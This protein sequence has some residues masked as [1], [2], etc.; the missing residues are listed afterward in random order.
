MTVSFRF[1]MAG[2]VDSE[3]HFEARAN[4]YGV[5]ANFLQALRREGI[6]TVGHLAF[7]VF[8]PGAEFNEREFDNWAQGVNNNVP[9]T[10]GAAAAVRRSDH[11]I[12]NQVNCGN[13]RLFHAKGHTICRKDSQDGADK[14]EVARVEHHWCW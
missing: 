2:L 3:A 10:M 4:E 14:V 12:D 8:R 13:S 7:A 6:T 5:P 11:D 9:L 1:K